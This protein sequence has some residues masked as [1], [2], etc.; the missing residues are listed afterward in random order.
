MTQ[1]SRTFYVESGTKTFNFDFVPDEP[2]SEK[3][4]RY[5]Q[6]NCETCEWK[7][8]S[9]AKNS[10][11]TGKVSETSGQCPSWQI[12]AESYYKGYIKYYEEL[13]GCTM[14]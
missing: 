8:M 12:D 5:F 4:G 6:H 9:G 3:L 13:S 2:T 11:C 7:F 1:Y 10:H 14:V